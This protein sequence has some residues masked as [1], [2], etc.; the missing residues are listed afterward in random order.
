MAIAP[1]E[2]GGVA[3]WF[4]GTGRAVH[5]VT[6]HAIARGTAPQRRRETTA[7]ARSMVTATA[8]IA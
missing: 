5:L 1:D 6:A 4:E 8:R 3:G 7:T 2:T